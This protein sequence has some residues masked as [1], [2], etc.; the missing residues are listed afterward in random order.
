[1]IFDHFRFS[2]VMKVSARHFSASK[3]AAEHGRTRVDLLA[4]MLKAAWQ[5]GSRIE[6]D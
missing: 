6:S 5:R 4:L 3:L 1:M 2:P